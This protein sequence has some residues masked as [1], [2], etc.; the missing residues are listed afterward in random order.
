MIHLSFFIGKL[1]STISRSF[2]DNV[3]WLYLQIATFASF[4]KEE[5]FECTLE[6]SHLANINRETCTCNFDTEVEI[7]KVVFLTDIPMAECILVK[8]WFN[9]AFFDNNI[10][11][12]ILAFRNIVVRNIR[13][14]QQFMNHV[15]L[16]FIHHLF[17]FFVCRFQFGYLILYFIGFILF[18]I[19]HQTANAF[20][21][22]VLLLFV[23]IKLLL[24]FASGFIQI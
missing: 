5:S 16:S 1:T 11:V 12:G 15:L 13:N 20:C 22:L 24:R 10:V 3:R 21:K 8:V 23:G 4:V 18:P 7:D 14:L 6:T 17:E 9:A 19:F 2:V